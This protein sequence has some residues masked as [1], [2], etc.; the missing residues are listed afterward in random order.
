MSDAPLSLH[1]R[2]EPVLGLNDAILTREMGAPRRWCFS[3]ELKAASV[4]NTPEPAF[5]AR[6]R[7]GDPVKA[8][9]VWQGQE[10]SPEV[11]IVG[12]ARDYESGHP[13]RLDLYAEHTTVKASGKDPFVPRRRVHRADNMKELVG[14]FQHL[15]MIDMPRLGDELERLQFPDTKGKACIVQDGLSDWEFLGLILDHCRWMTPEAPWL[16]LTLVGGAKGRWLIVPGVKQ[17]YMNWGE[18]RVRQLPAFAASDGKERFFFSQLESPS[19]TLEYPN[20]RFPLLGV[21]RPWR[22]FDA[23]R[24]LQ[25]RNLDLPLFTGSQDMVWRTTDRIYRSDGDTISWHSR[26]EWAPPRPQ[27][28]FQGSVRFTP[29]VGRGEVSASNPKGPWMQVKLAGFEEGSDTVDVRVST[30][31]SGK[32]GKLGLNFVPEEGTK[33]EVIWSGRFDSAIVLL[34]N[35]RWD[36]TQFSSPSICLEDTLTAQY[37][38]VDVKRIGNVKIG[39]NLSVDVNSQTQLHSQGQCKINADGADLKLSGGVVYTGRGM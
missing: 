18:N 35:T 10:I 27:R 36:A 1:F 19:R 28:G 29:W 22:S 32:D 15:A 38:D 34:G 37:E 31:F 26:F 2:G 7:A 9:A 24:W 23:G 20:G 6:F 12:L 3:A 33:V 4:E 13:N 11:S 39:S 5:M 21:E 8:K 25:W 14:Q 16:P 30:P 17:P